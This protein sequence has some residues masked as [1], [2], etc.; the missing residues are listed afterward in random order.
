ML[1]LL[2][3]L[4]VVVAAFGGLILLR[5]PESP[6]GTVRTPV[7]EVSSIGAGLPLIAIG[8]A[9]VA[10]AVLTNVG[11]GT[12]NLPE[13]GTSSSQSSSPEAAPT[14]PPAPPAPTTTPTNPSEPEEDNLGPVGS[15]THADQ[16]L[17]DDTYIDLDRAV[18]GTE[19]SPTAEFHLRGERFFF[20]ERQNV[21]AKVEAAIV[22]DDEATS[23]GCATA[24]HRIV[25]VV[26]LNEVE[27]DQ[28]ICIKTSRRRWAVVK[29]VD[30]DNSLVN[31]SVTINI[32]LR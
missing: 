3:A 26:F 24:S 8:V 7:G 6:G 19:S 23:R 15:P 21:Y 14:D 31:E 13:G 32:W 30:P 29:Q 17:G 27:P 20:D 10:I 16:Q 22:P 4:G 9:V 12:T 18:A 2:V 28:S 25:D 5:F 11:D 1:I